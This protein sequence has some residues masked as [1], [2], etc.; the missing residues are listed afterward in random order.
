MKTRF[1]KI[2]FVFA[3]VCLAIASISGEL[4]TEPDTTKWTTGSGNWNDATHWS[5]G[6][7]NAMTGVEIQGNGTVWVPEGTYPV[8]N[9]YVGL[10]YYDHARLRWMVG[11]HYLS[12]IPSM[13]E[14][15]ERRRG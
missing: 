9:L 11:N 2:A 14:R 10:H 5:A 15:T 8:A 12:G 3:A 7:P 1:P 6:L 4:E 13:R